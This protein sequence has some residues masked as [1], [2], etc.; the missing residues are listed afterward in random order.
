MSRSDLPRDSLEARA[1][2]RVRRKIGFYTHAM[3]FVMVHLGFGIAFLVGARH[4]PFFIWGWAVGLAIHGLFTFATLQGEGLR[5]RMLRQEIERM[6][7]ERGEPDKPIDK[8]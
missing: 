5:E 8:P 3:V 7:R 1:L 2:H 4:K 6:R